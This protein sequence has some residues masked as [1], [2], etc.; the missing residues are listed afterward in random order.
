MKIVLDT[1]VLVSGLLNPH[2]APSDLL[3]MV[4][5]GKLRV[6]YDARI[7][8]E[9]REVLLRPRFGFEPARVGILL[10]QIGAT[11]VPVVASPLDKPLPDVDDEPFLEVACSGGAEFLITGN[12]KHYPAR[13]R[14][15]VPVVSPREFMGRYRNRPKS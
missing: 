13:S 12:L 6:C 15:E 3:R 14:R 2:G 10:D 8:S 11:G 7:L 1:N 4:I 9:Y 5:A